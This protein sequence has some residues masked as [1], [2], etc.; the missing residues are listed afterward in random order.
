VVHDRRESTN[1][2][3]HLIEQAAVR[4]VGIARR[5]R[6]GECTR[7]SAAEHGDEDDSNREGREEDTQPPAVAPRRAGYRIRCGIDRRRLRRLRLTE[8]GGGSLL[9][10]GDHRQLRRFAAIV[11]VVAQCRLLHRH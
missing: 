4:A 11:F 9:F 2:A 3:L 1:R 5:I 8:R 6:C 7:E 10:W